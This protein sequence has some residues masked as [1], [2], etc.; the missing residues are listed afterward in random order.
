MQNLFLVPASESN[1]RA[2]IKKAI[3]FSRVQGIIPARTLD[4]LEQIFDYGDGFYCWA[5]TQS[6][7]N[8]YNKMHNGDIVILKPN[9][10]NHNEGY[11]KYKG[12]VIFKAICPELG[13]A[14]WPSGTGWEL[15]YFFKKIK[16]VTIKHS[17]LA[18]RLHYEQCVSPILQGTM[19]VASERIHRFIPAGNIDRFLDSID[20]K[21]N[22]SLDL[23]ERKIQRPRTPNNKEK[24]IVRSQ[25][26]KGSFYVYFF[27][28]FLLLLGLFWLTD[29]FHIIL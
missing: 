15:I 4:Q 3:P 8:I 17:V 12:S 24:K 16:E 26:I 28:L 5:M 20:E 21:N 29:W 10:Q 23:I 13:N 22:R 6:R 2:T 11:F 27:L 1:L 19:R 25:A 18:E 14:L 7:S 9:G